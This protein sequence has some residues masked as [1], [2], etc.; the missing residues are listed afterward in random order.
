MCPAPE[1]RLRPVAM[2]ASGVAGDAGLELDFA[3]VHYP[4]SAERGA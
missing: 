3:E 1:E 4:V 2:G